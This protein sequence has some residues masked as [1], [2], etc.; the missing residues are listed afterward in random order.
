[1]V[2]VLDL[3]VGA[4]E[5][6]R[7]KTRG[8]GRKAHEERMVIEAKRRRDFCIPV[9]RTARPGQRLYV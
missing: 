4:A 7:E 9:L 2:V 3:D 8:E 6:V 1:M 5:T